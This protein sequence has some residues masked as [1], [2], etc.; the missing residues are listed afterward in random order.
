MDPKNAQAMSVY[1]V[2][3]VKKS[4][5]SCTPVVTAIK[6]DG[7]Y[8]CEHI[9]GQPIYALIEAPSEHDAIRVAAQ[10]I[11]EITEK[12]FGKDYLF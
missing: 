6:L 9:G 1:K 4:V 8:H 11:T 3:F 2:N 7:S 5:V 10:I 12:T